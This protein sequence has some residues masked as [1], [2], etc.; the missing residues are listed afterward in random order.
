MALRPGRSFPQLRRSYLSNTSTRG[1]SYVFPQPDPGNPFMNDTVFK[2]R[3]NA[4]I[5]GQARQNRRAARAATRARKGT[6]S[7]L[8]PALSAPAGSAASPTAQ[9]ATR[10]QKSMP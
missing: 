2:G 9:R 1:Q 10:S 6:S 3:R 5:Q 7:T 4:S 8:W